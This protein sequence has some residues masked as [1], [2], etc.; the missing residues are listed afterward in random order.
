MF[1]P[2]TP[3]YDLIIAWLIMKAFR[4]WQSQQDIAAFDK[5]AFAQSSKKGRRGRATPSR[6]SLRMYETLG[7]SRRRQRRSSER[8]RIRRTRRKAG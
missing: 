2:I 6:T 8:G 7:V 5:T 3:A 4:D 1:S